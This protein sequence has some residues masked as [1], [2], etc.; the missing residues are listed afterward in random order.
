MA[1]FAASRLPR[2]IHG[3][4]SLVVHHFDDLVEYVP[5][6][7]IEIVCADDQLD[8]IVRAIETTAHTGNKG[9]GKIYV[10]NVEQAIRIRTGE[11][12]AS[13]A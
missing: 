10:T 11:R 13:A 8:E 3:R 7:K 12:G 2:I 1:S 5:H 9:D 4:Q 6:V